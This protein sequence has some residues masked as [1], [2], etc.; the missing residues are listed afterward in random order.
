MEV[1]GAYAAHIASNSWP[2]D[3]MSAGA[4]VV[5]TT[6]SRLESTAARV[7]FCTQVQRQGASV[8]A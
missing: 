7:Q 3:C 1:L 4:C 2:N 8:C 6:F 5:M